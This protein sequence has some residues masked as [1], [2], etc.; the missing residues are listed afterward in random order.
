MAQGA[1]REYSWVVKTKQITKHFEFAAQEA[2]LFGTH[3]SI[4]KKLQLP[5]KNMLLTTTILAASCRLV[6]AQPPAQGR[7]YIGNAKDAP[8]W[9]WHVSTASANTNQ[10]AANA[11]WVKWVELTSTQQRADAEKAALDDMAVRVEYAAN[12]R[13][14]MLKPEAGGVQLMRQRGIIIDY[15]PTSLAGVISGEDGK[16][17]PFRAAEWIVSSVDSHRGLW[18]D[19]VP[20]SETGYALF[21]SNLGP[22][23]PEHLE[24]ESPR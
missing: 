5:M 3:Q 23:T 17:W 9:V 2:C 1:L 19:F 18:V 20:E 11:S 14:R 22:I 10:T 24:L 15:N 7:I 12:P 16:R 4:L 13:N 8:E 21:I 6:M